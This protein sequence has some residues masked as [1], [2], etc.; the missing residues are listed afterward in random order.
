VERKLVG[1]PPSASATH[2]EHLVRPQHTNAMGTLFGGEVMAWV[3]TV[4][5]VA[6]MRHTEKP[7]VTASIDTLHFLAPIRLGWI[8]T[9]DASV[10]FSGRTSCEV[11]VKVVAQ[12]PIRGEHHHTASAYLT[13]VALDANGRPTPMPPVI[14]E[15]PKDKERFEAAQ[16][17]R[18]ARLTLKDTLTKRFG[19]KP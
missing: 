5:A 7:V 4:A 1:K 3:D 8:V 13:F 12:D 9:L 15:T 6:A 17:R 18:R 11:G 14:P 10:N 2:H 16:E 19:E